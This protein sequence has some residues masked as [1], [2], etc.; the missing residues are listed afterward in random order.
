[1]SCLNTL[2]EDEITQKKKKKKE[3]KSQ[4]FLSI[5]AQEAY[6]YIEHT[7]SYRM[8]SDLEKVQTNT[9]KKPTILNMYQ[10]RCKLLYF[11]HN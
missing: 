10:F 7:K 4:N 1:M 9:E 11:I 3:K 2:Y 6:N 5:Q 8:L